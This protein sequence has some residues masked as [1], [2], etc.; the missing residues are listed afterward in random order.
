MPAV[1]RCLASIKIMRRHSYV[2]IY[3][4]ITSISSDHILWVKT[5]IHG[6]LGLT[7]VT[8]Q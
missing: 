2:I 7:L 1:Q 6:E 4:I 8:I 5:G 3:M